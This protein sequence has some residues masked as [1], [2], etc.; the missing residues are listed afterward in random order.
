ML[1]TVVSIGGG[2]GGE[3]NLVFVARTGNGAPVGMPATGACLVSRTTVAAGTEPNTGMCRAKYSEPCG[4][5]DELQ[6]VR[7]ALDPI[8]AWTR[9]GPV[10]IVGRNVPSKRR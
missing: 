1:K 7:C 2:G 6:S 5:S 10:P 8:R 4:W 9:M 3:C